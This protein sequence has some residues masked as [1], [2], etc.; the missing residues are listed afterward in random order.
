MKAMFDILYS[1]EKLKSICKCLNNA[2]NAGMGPLAWTDK[3]ETEFN[4]NCI[5]LVWMEDR[6]Y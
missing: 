5:Y 6:N 1:P 2:Q 3:G 4:L